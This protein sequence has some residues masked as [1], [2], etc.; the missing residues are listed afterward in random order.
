MGAVSRGIRNAF[1]NS[2]RTVSIVFILAVSVGMAIV[3]LVALKTVQAKIA[4]VKSS[5]GNYITVSP[6]GIR[7]FEG[8]G[9]LLT[10]QNATDVAALAH[11][12][13]V[14]KTLTDRLRQEGSTSNTSLISPTTAGSF[15]N[16]QRRFQSDENGDSTSN[17]PPAMPIMITGTNNLDLLSTINA[18]KLDLTSGEKFD[19][20][21]S[22]NIAMIGK[23][24]ASKNNLAV[25]Q[26]FKAYSTDIRV[27]GIF[28]AGNNFA[29]AA[30]IMPIKTVQALSSQANQINSLIVRADS[31]DSLSSVKTEIQNKLGAD[32]VDVTS[33]Q[34]TEQNAIAPLENIKT[35]S[36]FSL[37][38]SLIAGAVIIFLTMVMIVRERRR[39]IGV[40]KAIG[41][42]NATIVTQFA[43]E[44]LVLTL[45]GSIFGTI[46]GIILSNPVL[47]VLINNSS[48]ASQATRPS[49]GPGQM[50][51]MGAELGA[52][53]QN[54]L[55]DL[56]AAVGTDIIL[57]GLLAAI[58]IA[59]L[60]SIIPSFTIAKVRPAE[61]L[62]S[63]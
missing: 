11:V 36:L 49:D 54:S 24:L 50:M 60:G 3:M 28:D 46:L 55:K 32:K 52:R 58:V 63:E 16:R 29:N 17:T 48:S 62:R 57:Y 41:G 7:G 25:G 27:V 26:T 4:N 35:I 34:D 14:S 38:G 43:V 18:S 30:V 2:I 20:N 8:G 45:L 21:S 13:K 37:I 5:I 6:A 51:R 31:I 56:H 15:G 61:V 44:S 10:E 53:A 1:R 39:E 12:E 47:S 42:S 19:P 33:S 40:L 9:E 22:E 23:E 59:I